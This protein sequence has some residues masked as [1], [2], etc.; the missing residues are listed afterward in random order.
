M[1]VCVIWERCV[2]S[3]VLATVGL[4]V[5]QMNIRTRVERKI[6]TS[7]CAQRDVPLQPIWP[8]FVY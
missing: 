2:G 6:A 5:Q 1:C 4:A 8:H 3:P 7:A